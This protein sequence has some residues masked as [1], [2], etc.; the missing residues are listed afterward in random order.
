M[1]LRLKGYRLVARRW[2]CPVGEIDLIV[3]RGQILAF[4]EVK[5]RRTVDDA[6]ESIDRRTRARIARAARVFL[7]QRPDLS[8]L[9]ARFD[10]VLVAPDRWPDH[11][12]DAWQSE[13]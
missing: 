9:D 1:V 3:R 6:A 10:A 13:A 12:V 2:R 5:A 11:R 8:V 7:Q 4:V